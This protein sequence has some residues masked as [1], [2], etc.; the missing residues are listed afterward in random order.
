MLNEQNDRLFEID[1]E[2]ELRNYEIFQFLGSE[3]Q[4]SRKFYKAEIGGKIVGILNGGHGIKPQIEKIFD[5]LYIIS[6]DMNIY[7]FN[8]QLQKIID[9]K[10]DSIIYKIHIH[11]TGVIVACELDFYSL[12]LLNLNINW[13]TPFPSIITDFNIDQERIQIVT[14]GCVKYLIDLSNGNFC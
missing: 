6:T 11:S 5:G 8:V 12:D 7:L 9:R 14:D 1:S 10:L 13:H 3:L 4:Y 2:S